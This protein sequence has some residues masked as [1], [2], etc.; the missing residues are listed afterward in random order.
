[1]KPRWSVESSTACS[2]TPTQRSTSSF[3]L[4]TNLERATFI[5]NRSFSQLRYPRL[6]AK[7]SWLRP[8]PSLE[9]TSTGKAPWPRGFQVIIRLAANAPRRWRPLSSNVRAT[10]G[11]VRL[12]LGCLMRLTPARKVILA[13]R[14]EC[15]SSEQARRHSSLHLQSSALAVRRGIGG[16]SASGRPS[17]GGRLTNRCSP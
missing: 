9:R 13:L 16:S 6:H 8:N 7:Q 14:A 12:Q 3:E 10:H 1:M 5:Q 15:S 11:A 2:R 17:R 4:L